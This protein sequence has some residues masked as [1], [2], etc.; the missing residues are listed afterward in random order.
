[1]LSCFLPREPQQ[2]DF[3]PG[4]ASACKAEIRIEENAM[5]FQHTVRVDRIYPHP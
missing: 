5:F 3:T 1:M 2:N 4:E